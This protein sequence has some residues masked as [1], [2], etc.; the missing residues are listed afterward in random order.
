MKDTTD[1]ADGVKSGALLNERPSVLLIDDE[2]NVLLA[3]E[4]GLSS[5]CSLAT[6]SNAVEAFAQFSS[7][8]PFSVVVSDLRM[9][10]LGGVEVLKA[11]HC[12]SPAT[13]GILLTGSADLASA[14]E[15]INS[16]QVFKF[17]SKPCPIPALL[18]A[19]QEG[20]ALY[21]KATAAEALMW[22]TSRYDTATNLPNR[23]RFALDFLEHKDAA[24][25]MYV[26]AI[27]AE[28]TTQLIDT[29][30]V[31]LVDALRAQ[32]AERWINKTPIDSA[33]GSR[34]YSIGHNFAL[35]LRAEN[36]SEAQ[37]TCEAFLAVLQPAFD[38][39]GHTLR[40]RAR[41]GLYQ[42]R[43]G[44][45]ALHALR[46]AE[47]ACRAAPP[48]SDARVGVFGPQSLE[49]EHRRDT[50]MQALRSPD[51]YQQL[52]LVFQPQ[53]HLLR[54]RLFGLEALCRWTMPQ[55]GEISPAE[56]LPLMKELQILDEVDEWALNAACGY[57]Q[58]LRHALPS[59]ARIS[60]NISVGELH[61]GDFAGRVNAALER[62]GLP[63]ALLE[64]EL[65]ETEAVAN[66]Q[67]IADSLKS[68]TA[69][70][71]SLA[72]DNFGTGDSTLSYVGEPPAQIL[73]IDRTLTQR[74]TTR[75]SGRDLIERVIDLGHGCGMPVV[76]EGVENQ[77]QSRMLLL[78][79]CDA[80]QGYWLAKPLEADELKDWLKGRSAL[81]NT[82]RYSWRESKDSEADSDTA[83]AASVGAQSQT[84]PREDSE[85][86]D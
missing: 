68:L 50:L 38:L 71:V 31:A 58:T 23:N 41:A 76:A 83:L 57:R 13:A 19:I 14:T 6:A 5:H 46:C 28:D 80:I 78:L 18:A 3:L 22:E 67:H 25:H 48:G 65:T 74:L 26:A 10:D 75:E 73:K 9:P 39:K 64:I 47:A 54:D 59:S 61:R 37:H 55:W 51:L 72:I 1:P 24:E 62:S 79:G 30:G 70:G 15:A 69:S 86:G 33:G 27:A 81:V 77:Q 8:G 29:Y 63:P 56:F 60:V 21:L 42:C 85:G 35:L 34:A 11:I 53:W 4:R 44:D 16:A 12:R 82:S 84:T 20:H 17:L 7:A 43:S 52:R 66:S 2:P 36:E 40:L 49:K 45:D 32:I